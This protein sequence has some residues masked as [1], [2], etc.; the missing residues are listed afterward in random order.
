[1][2]DTRDWISDLVDD[3]RNDQPLVTDGTSRKLLG[4]LR[5]EMTDGSLKPKELTSLADDLLASMSESQKDN[6]E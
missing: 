6:T 3:A 4:L 5:Q 1:M 2:A